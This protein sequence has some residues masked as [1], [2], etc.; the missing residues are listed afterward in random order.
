M[1]AIVQR[2]VHRVVVPMTW[3]RF[4][5]AT[6]IM[7]IFNKIKQIFSLKYF[8]Y[9]LLNIFSLC[10]FLKIM[11]DVLSKGL[12]VNFDLFINE[13]ISLLR[14]IW[15]DKIM[16]F[17]TSIFD[18]LNLL[19]LSLILLSLSVYWKKWHF[20]SLYSTGLSAGIIFGYILKIIV[21]RDRPTG[22]VISETDFSFP[23]NHAIVAAIFFPLL[24]YFLKNS[25]KNKLF[26]N[27]F[28][29]VNIFFFLTIGFSRIYLKV[30][31]FSDVIAG[32]SI[33]LFWL[34]FLVLINQLI[35]LLRNKKI[36]S[37]KL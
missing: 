27:I 33:G 8:C 28:L 35:N 23:S 4:P 13:R 6:L 37:E 25:I 24:Y 32:F 20:F 14:H 19:I 7:R 9:L 36:S 11:N 29:I 1:V 30:H 26:K 2:L 12:I 10:G 22:G 3:V 31:W 5:V 21:Q 15:L 17:F 16:I 34:T 18:P